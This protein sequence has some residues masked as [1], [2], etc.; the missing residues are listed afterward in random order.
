M[1]VGILYGKE[2]WLNQMPPYQTGGEMIKKVSFEEASFNSLPYKFETGTPN[3]ADVVG[4][5]AA[6]KYLE[7][8]G[9]EAIAETEDNLM[10]YALQQM[11]SMEGIE[12][13]APET[14]RAGVISFN[15]KGIH[16]FDAGT[17]IDQLGI[18][19][20][21]GNHCAQPL[22]DLLGIQGTIRASFAFYNTSDEIDRLIEAI[23]TVQKMFG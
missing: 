13:Y 7:Q 19:V 21:T 8:L 2:K 20:R 15:L 6:I 14:T 12:I 9:T 1:G 11:K 4:F 22:M 18:A 5:D 10:E 3:V 17:I 16:P 23:R